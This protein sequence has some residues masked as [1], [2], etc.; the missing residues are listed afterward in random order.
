MARNAI[1]G[2]GHRSRESSVLKDSVGLC[3]ISNTLRELVAS[4][5]RVRTRYARSSLV[6]CL[7]LIIV[8]L[9]GKPCS[10]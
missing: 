3:E 1:A 6:Q 10:W 7:T 5:I 9:N 4:H 2:L 8:P